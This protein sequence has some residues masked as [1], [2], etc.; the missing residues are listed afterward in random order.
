MASGTISWVGEGWLRHFL[1]RGWS[2]INDGLVEVGRKYLGWVG[3][4]WGVIWGGCIMFN[5]VL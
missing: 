2:I 4:G 1:G 3:L 5:N